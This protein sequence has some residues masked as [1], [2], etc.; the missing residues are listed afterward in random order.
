MITLEGKE[1]LW[2]NVLKE[3][4]SDPLLGDLHFT[5]ALMTAI[6]KRAEKVMSYSEIG[7]IARNKF[8]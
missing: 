2:Q 6:R 1:V 5:R 8:A 7:L 3:F 4:P